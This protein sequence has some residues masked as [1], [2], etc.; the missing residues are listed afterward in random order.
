MNIYVYIHTY[1][2]TYIHVYKH[3]KL[4]SEKKFLLTFVGQSHYVNLAALE[5]TM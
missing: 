1:I 4:K 3:K 5:L 2:Y